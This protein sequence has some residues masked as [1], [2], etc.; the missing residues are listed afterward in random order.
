ML[1]NSLLAIHLARSTRAPSRHPAML[2]VHLTPDRHAYHAGDTVRI[3]IRFAN[4][5]GRETPKRDEPMRRRRGLVGLGRG[6][7]GDQGTARGEAGGEEVFPLPPP[8]TTTTTTDPV[9]PIPR[10]HPHARKVSIAQL[11]T[12]PPNE[13]PGPR[14]RPGASSSSP[15]DPIPER[16]GSSP[17]TTSPA[18]ARPLSIE[19]HLVKEPPPPLPPPTNRGCTVTFATAH[20]HG[21]FTPSPSYIPP[22]P[23]IP[24][25]SLLTHQPIGSGTLAS[26]QTGG[27][28]MDRAAGGQG[29]TGSL[30]SLARG[31]IGAA[32]EPGTWD[33]RKREV[34]TGRGLAVWLGA[35]EVVAVDV[36]IDEGAAVECE[37]WVSVTC[38]RDDT[39][40]A[41]SE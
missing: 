21:T 13:N 24:L 29:L 38:K 6:E 30:T 1:V 22:E 4:G 3:R 12:P 35:R 16:A 27:T 23:L 34:W 5:V 33:E 32:G 7:T 15:L 10:H 9:A 28:I 2:A 31:L 39:G 37:F 40:A 41:L 17:A 25:R 26:S 20:P 19:P 36:R 14:P 11:P 18:S 8:P